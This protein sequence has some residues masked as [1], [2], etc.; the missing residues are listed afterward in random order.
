MGI[1]IDYSF[2]IQI[3]SFLIL[4]VLLKR[5]LFDPVLHVLEQRE[6]RTSGNRAA[7]EQLAEETRVLAQEYDER[8]RAARRSALEQAEEKRKLALDEERRVLAAARNAGGAQLDQT[9]ADIRA[10]VEVA[11][12]GLR[13]DAADLAARVAEKILGRAAA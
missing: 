6:T 13:R 4:W 1:S 9:R 7:A 10:A 2:A 11:R 5:L 8:I 12:V 3:A